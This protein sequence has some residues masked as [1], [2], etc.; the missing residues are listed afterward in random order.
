MYCS[1]QCIWMT[2]EQNQQLHGNRSIKCRSADVY[3]ILIWQIKNNCISVNVI[4]EITIYDGQQTWRFF[5][6]V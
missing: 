2:F 3:L 4:N 6:I 1:G 5:S